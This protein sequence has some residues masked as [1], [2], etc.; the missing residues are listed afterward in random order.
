MARRPSIMIAAA[1]PGDSPGAGSSCGRGVLLL[2]RSHGSPISH[3]LLA[4]GGL[5]TGRGRGSATVA[6]M[7][8]ISEPECQCW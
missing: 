2:R 6:I 4:A 5:C 7:T 1:G 8:R 3:R